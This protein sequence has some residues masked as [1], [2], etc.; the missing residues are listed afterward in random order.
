MMNGIT[1]LPPGIISQE[2]HVLRYFCRPRRYIIQNDSEP[3]TASG[4][5]YRVF[6]S[7]TSA[8]ESSRN[9]V[10]EY[11]LTIE[12]DV[13]S[14]ERFF[15]A[16]STISDL[17]HD[18]DQFWLYSIGE[19]LFP[20]T[21]RFSFDSIP[22]GWEANLDDVKQSLLRSHRGA[23]PVIRPIV[24]SWLELPHFPLKSALRARDAYIRADPTIQALADLHYSA[25]KLP[26]NE[27]KL[28]SLKPVMHFE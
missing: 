11:A 27:G 14:S 12:T 5:G 17:A 9:S 21:L 28:F 16:V 15:Q 3:M 13:S 24:Q 18:L 4:D 8:P 20:V 2:K 7:Y 26:V 25:V 6:E 10:G 23:Y 1:L 19:P 22:P